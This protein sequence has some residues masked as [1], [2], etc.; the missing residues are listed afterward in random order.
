MRLRHIYL[1]FKYHPN[2]ELQWLGVSLVT[3]AAA[4][5]K[6]D[7]TTIIL[8]V[9]ALFSTAMTSCFTYFMSKTRSEVVATNVKVDDLKIHINS[10]M[11]KMIEALEAAAM[12]K[13]HL[14]GIE[15]ERVR[16]LTE[17]SDISRAVSLPPGITQVKMEQTPE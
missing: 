13:G 10:R 17:E 16:R 12:A 14:A 15:A 6:V 3:C 7:L 5:A 9:I 2:L 8:A 1:I 11:D 4:V